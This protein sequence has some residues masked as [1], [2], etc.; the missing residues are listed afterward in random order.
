MVKTIAERKSAL[1]VWVGLGYLTVVLIWG[2][3]WFAIGTQVNGTA[4]HVAVALRLG[5]ASAIHFAMLAAL[6]LPL[7]VRRRQIGTV[8]LQGIRFYDI[9]IKILPRIGAVA[10]AYIVVLSPVIAVGIS[11]AL[12]GLPLGLP[13]LLGVA[14]LLVGHSLVVLRG[15]R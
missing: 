2:T 8:L 5:I 11:A 15:L 9:Y 12:E 4:P 6:G 13:T 1:N 10:G 3:T 7:R 14:L